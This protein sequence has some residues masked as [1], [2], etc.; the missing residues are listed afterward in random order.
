MDNT[1]S[2]P[3]EEELI[4]ALPEIMST[5]TG[6]RRIRLLEQILELIPDSMA[7]YRI[8]RHAYQLGWSNDA[9]SP[10]VTGDDDDFYST[11]LTA[12][13]HCRQ[14]RLNVAIEQTRSLVILRP[15][16]P[17][18]CEL[19]ANLLHDGLEHELADQLY[20][21][22][23]PHYAWPSGLNR[24]GDR[25]FQAL[26]P[27]A[28]TL[29]SPLQWLHRKEAPSPAVAV[30][31][32]DPRYLER[33]LP[34]FLETFARHRAESG[35]SLHLHIVN[36]DATH[37]SL[38]PPHTDDLLCGITCETLDLPREEIHRVDLCREHRTYYA[39]AR[40]R[41]LP[42]LLEHYACPLWVL[43]IDI[44]INRSLSTLCPPHYAHTDIAYIP[45]SAGWAGPF[46]SC[47]VTIFGIFPTPMGLQTAQ[48]IRASI[49][50]RLAIGQSGWGLD[51]AV[52]ANTLCYMRRHHPDFHVTPLN[53]GLVGSKNTPTESPLLT[54]LVGSLTGPS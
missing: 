46:V 3:S 35:L 26:P 24:C 16:H 28:R 42:M 40:F 8:L 29:G 49:E 44:E 45:L 21:A 32:A 34:K 2:P 43:D 14:G 20:T 12:Y 31:S 27:H 53:A 39:C 51:Q 13:E 15:H 25:Y 10:H 52:I 47:F 37:L 38:I 11:L 5:T 36:G 54:S 4:A 19:L 23:A 41:L 50:E 22:L 6:V 48:L 33:Y 9:P 18:A 30:I 17:V 1:P 7:A